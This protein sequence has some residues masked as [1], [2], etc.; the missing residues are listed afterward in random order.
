MNQQPTSWADAP[1][2]EYTK[3]KLSELL[4]EIVWRLPGITELEGRKALEMA[5][6]KFLRATKAWREA[7]QLPPPDVW[8]PFPQFFFGPAAGLLPSGVLA[9]A[10][11]TGM[12]VPV[13]LVSPGGPGPFFSPHEHWALRLGPTPAIY[14]AGDRI[15]FFPILPPIEVYKT[16]APGDDDVPEEVLKRWGSAIADGAFADLAF[17]P[18]KPWSDPQGAQLAANR[19]HN[20]CVTA[21]A[22]VEPKD[23]LGQPTCRNPIPFC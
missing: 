7:V 17:Q 23:A 6:D 15:P 2:K 4:G 19:F 11:S 13:G 21:R 16:I 9:C 8:G 14:W 1:A 20:A 3:G 10:C 5:A 22:E 18:Q 12:G